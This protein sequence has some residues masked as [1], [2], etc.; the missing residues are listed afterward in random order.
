MTVRH[1]HWIGGKAAAPAGGSY[2]PTLDPSTREPGDEIAAGS[3]V[4]VDRAVTDAAAA[5]PQWARRSGAERGELLHRVA[6]VIDAHAAELMELERVATGKIATQLRFEVEQ[7]AAYFRYYAGVVRARHGR[8]IDLGGGSHTYTRLEPY[9][10]VAAITP[11]NLPLNQACRAL[12]PA[13]AAGNAV[14]VKP[15]ELTSISTVRLARLAS[16]AGLPDGLFNVVTGTGPEVG[17]PLAADPR[18]GRVTFTGSVATG[19]HLAR[20]AADRLVPATLELGGKS[21]LVV[22]ADADLDRAAAAAVSTVATNS[23]QVCSATT[24]LLVEA[25]VHDELVARVVAAVERLTPGVDFGPIITEAQYRKVLDFFA[26]TLASGLRPAT[27]GAAYAD[28]PGAKGLYIRPTVY[29]GVAPHLPVAREE[30]FGPVLVTLPFEGED[31]ALALANDSEYGLV[32]SVWSGDVARGLRL[33]ERIEAGQVAVNGGP[34]TVETPFGGYKASG[35]GREKG[36][37]ALH[38][39]ARVK[40]VSLSLY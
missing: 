2:L 38:E 3:P 37:E 9:G 13:L 4:D 21:P 15:S 29:A 10:V 11:W 30:V 33:A 18:V 19:R 8:T 28:G 22:F 39:Y 31:E 7:S 23:G 1:D 27:G 5:Q 14:V 25:S 24:R 20:I 35:Y 16:E 26:R 17:T 6:D 12:A 34:L 36:I 40:T 32:G